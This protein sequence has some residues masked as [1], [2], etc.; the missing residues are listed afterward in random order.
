ML[1]IETTPVPHVP[2]AERLTIDALGHKDDRITHVTARF[3][4][5][6]AGTRAWRRARG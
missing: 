3:G 5:M 6:A 4:Y 2:A 1:S